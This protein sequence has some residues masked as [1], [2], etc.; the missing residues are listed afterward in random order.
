MLLTTLLLGCDNPVG[1]AIGAPDG[2]TIDSGF[3]PGVQNPPAITSVSPNQGFFT[4]QIPVSIRGTGFQPGATVLIGASAC[5]SVIVSSPTLISCTVP[6]HAIASVDV[7]VTNPDAQFATLRSGYA[8]INAVMSPSTAVTLGGGT[9]TGTG[10]R[11]NMTIGE[12]AQGAR[13]SASGVSG[14]FGIQGSTYA[15]L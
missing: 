10:V 15:P 14:I 6:T 9:S 13:K 4:T 3:H 1:G 12:P 2:P 7:R 8:Y 5:L 11:M